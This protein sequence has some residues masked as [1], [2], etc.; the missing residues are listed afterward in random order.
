MVTLPPHEGESDPTYQS[1]LKDWLDQFNSGIGFPK[2]AVTLTILE[3]KLIAQYE[4]E[5][6]LPEIAK[7]RQT[8][9]EMA[10]A[11]GTGAVIAGGVAM[12]IGRTLLGGLAGR[13]GIAGAFGAIGLA[14]L[15]PALLVGATVGGIMYTVYKLGRDVTDNEQ[16]QTFGQE[17]SEHLLNFFPTSLPPMDM[18]I[19]ASIDRRITIIY[20][21]EL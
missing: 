12:L 7:L 11:S 14:P 8:G 17:L 1:E 15:V 21:P 20:D 5:S 18:A 4:P 16:A 19:V 9:K 3:K 10:I 6:G 13:V 2:K